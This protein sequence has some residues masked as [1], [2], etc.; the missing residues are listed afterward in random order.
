MYFQVK[1]QQNCRNNKFRDKK[2]RN[3][4]PLMFLDAKVL[5]ERLQ[6]RFWTVSTNKKSTVYVF[7]FER[8]QNNS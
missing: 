4:V 3:K 1:M 7:S 6:L 2:T 5:K 8:L